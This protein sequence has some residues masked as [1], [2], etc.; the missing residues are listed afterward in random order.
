[1]FLLTPPIS[2]HLML[3]FYC[4]KGL[5]HCVKIYISIHLMLR[6]YTHSIHIFIYKWNF[7]TSHVKVLHEYAYWFNTANWISI[8]L[9]L[10]F[11]EYW[12][13][14]SDTFWLISIHLM[15]RFYTFG[16]FKDIETCNFNTSHVKVLRSYWRNALRCI[17]ISIHLMLRFYFDVPEPFRW[18]EGFQYISC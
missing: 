11:Y 16:N 10:R 7:N 1:M 2:I 6:F 13:N 17:G 9:M 3:R 5:G 15:L 12:G 18:L 4:I 8:H 14:I